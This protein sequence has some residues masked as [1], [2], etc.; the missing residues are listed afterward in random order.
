MTPEGLSVKP[1]LIPAGS[2]RL[3][4]PTGFLRVFGG[5]G[6]TVLHIEKEQI[7]S[8]LPTPGPPWYTVFNVLMSCTDTKPIEKRMVTSNEGF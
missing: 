5:G 2:G 1:Y 8:P 4:F 3:L 7:K 6:T